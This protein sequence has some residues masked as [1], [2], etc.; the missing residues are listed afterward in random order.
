VV[1]GVVWGVVLMVGAGFALARA[2]PTAREQTTVAQARPVVDQATA[3]I[4]TAASSDGLAVVAVSGFDRVGGCDVTVLRS[5]ERYQRVVN[6]FV[7]PGTERALLER[8]AER[9]PAA[10]GASV[11][12]G[13]VPRLQADAGFWVLLTGAPVKPGQVRFVAD[14]G[15]CRPTGDLGHSS[16]A[17]ADRSTVEQTMASLG[18]PA[19]QWQSYR[20]ACPSGGSL[21]TVEATGADSGRVAFD[22]ALRGTGHP[23]LAEPDAYAYVVGTT[24]IA[25]RAAGGQ[26]VVSA[27]V[28]CGQ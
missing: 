1:I 23:V 24:G 15:D 10:Y 19:Q 20:I 2:G 13:T 12:H 21:S 5:G 18:V 3:Q 22:A 4:A 27:T 17:A 9:L 11:S 6:A 16:E 14:T 25:V 7:A 8:V 26:I 28:P